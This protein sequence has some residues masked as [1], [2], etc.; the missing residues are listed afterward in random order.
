MRTSSETPA[1]GHQM[2]GSMTP[3]IEQWLPEREVVLSPTTHPRPRHQST[4][5]P[6][7]S[8][9]THVHPAIQFCDHLA[10]DDHHRP[11]A[12][13]ADGD[14]AIRRHPLPGGGVDGGGGGMSMPKLFLIA[15]L[16]LGLIIFYAN[17]ALG[18]RSR[19][20]R[21]DLRPAKRDRGRGRAGNGGGSGGGVGSGTAVASGI[22]GSSGQLR[23]RA[24]PP[25]S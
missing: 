19:S 5:L 21:N 8:P 12:P 10:C 6:R 3:K 17:M 14:H 25:L 1:N 2:P 18:S 23:R 24:R 4:S 22:R 13:P 15:V 16:V 20:T 9:P 11:Y 7:W